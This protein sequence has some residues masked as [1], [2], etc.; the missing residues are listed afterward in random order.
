FSSGSQNVSRF[1]HSLSDMSVCA[2]TVLGSWAAVGLV[3]ED[4]IIADFKS[5][6][7]R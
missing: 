3:P 1:R 5:R 6:G 4:D 7:K 2:S